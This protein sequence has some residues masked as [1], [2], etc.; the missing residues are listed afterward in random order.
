MAR[1]IFILHSLRMS[2]DDPFVEGLRRIFTAN[3]TLKPS[4]ISVKAGLDNSTIRKL[5]SGANSSPKIETANRIADAMGYQ[6]A[7]VIAIGA[8]EDPSLALDWLRLLDQVTPEVR[9][10]AVKYALFL[11]S[12]NLAVAAGKFAHPQSSASSDYIQ[13]SLATDPE[14]PVR[15]HQDAHNSGPQGGPSKRKPQAKAS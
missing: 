1:R 9:D 6:L 13:G 3:P 8:H 14:S 11:Q 5:I 2:T 4:V 15:P 10:E 7:D 12:Q